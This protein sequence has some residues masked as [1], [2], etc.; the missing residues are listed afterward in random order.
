MVLEPFVDEVLRAVQPQ[1]CHPER[2]L[3]RPLRQPQ[4]KD[5]RLLS[6]FFDANENSLFGERISAS[7]TSHSRQ[8]Q[9]RG[10]FLH[11]Q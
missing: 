4:S 7:Y 9:V 1:N 10:R 11:E 2:R 3:A 6:S 5:L 8:L